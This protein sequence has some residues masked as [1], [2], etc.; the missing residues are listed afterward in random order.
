MALF[1]A[2]ARYESGP[3]AARAVVANISVSDAPAINAA[4]GRSVGSR[5]AGGY[6]EGAYNLLRLFAP[7]SSQK[8]NAFLRHERYDTQASVPA[9]GTRDRSLARRITTLGFTYKPTWNTA[10]KGDYQLL[11]NAAGAG[12]SEVLSLGVGYQF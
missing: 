4:Y 9:G 6:L 3:F 5:I 8:L 11:R 7:A 10:F 12:E 1:S 2:D